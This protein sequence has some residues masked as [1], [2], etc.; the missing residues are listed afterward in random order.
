MTAVDIYQWKPSRAISHKSFKS[1][2]IRFSY[3]A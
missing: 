2:D 1:Y 3:S